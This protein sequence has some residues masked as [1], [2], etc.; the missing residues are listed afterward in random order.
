MATWQFDV[1]F[2]PRAWAEAPGRTP[3]ALYDDEGAWDTGHCWSDAVGMRDRAHAL[4]CAEHGEPRVFMEGWWVWGN[5]DTDRF[6]AFEESGELRSLSVRIHAGRATRVSLGRIVHLAHVME[7]VLWPYGAAEWTD[8]DPRVLA[9]ALAASPAV[10]F[11]RD[12]K[13]FLRELAAK[14]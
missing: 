11:V 9:A 4:L 10:R 14:S 8:A 5:D 3:A 1:A 7:C 12:P 13:G 2:I 6:D